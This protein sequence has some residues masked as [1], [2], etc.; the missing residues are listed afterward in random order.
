MAS[1]RISV[2]DALPGRNSRTYSPA[3]KSRGC[4]VEVALGLPLVASA[5]V[6]L[7]GLVTAWECR[8]DQLCQQD[9]RSGIMH[10]LWLYIGC[11]KLYKRRYII[12]H[13]QRECTSATDPFVR[14]FESLER[15]RR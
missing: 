7:L 8:W 1:S 4:L 12:W 5:H 2:S 6:P 9:V 11:I 10:E 14:P 13:R 3:A 15:Q